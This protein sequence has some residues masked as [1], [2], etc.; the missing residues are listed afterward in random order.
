MV[1]IVKDNE[2][3]IGDSIMVYEYKKGPEICLI[4]MRINIIGRSRPK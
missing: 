3:T 1:N 2:L 4:C